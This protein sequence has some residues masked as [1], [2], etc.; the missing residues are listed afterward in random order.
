[1]NIS[2]H[3]QGR[4]IVSPA[5]SI[6]EVEQILGQ[7]SS[8]RSRRSWSNQESHIHSESLSRNSSQDL[9]MPY[10]EDGDTR[11]LGNVGANITTLPI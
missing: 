10:N 3:G 7:K 5:P 9:S 6:N 11:N 8:S 4:K 2:N 1:M